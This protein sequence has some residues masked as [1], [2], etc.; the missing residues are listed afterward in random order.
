MERPCHHAML[1]LVAERGHRYDRKLDAMPPNWES[2]YP[3]CTKQRTL[4]YKESVLIYYLMAMG[5]NPPQ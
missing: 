4:F 1:Y 5:Y 2:Y 3:Y